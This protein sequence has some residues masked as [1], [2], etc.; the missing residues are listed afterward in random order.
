MPWHHP[1]DMQS[2][3]EIESQIKLSQMPAHTEGQNEWLHLRFSVHSFRSEQMACQS[4][5]SCGCSQ[6]ILK[7]R[8]RWPLPSGTEGDCICSYQVSQDSAEWTRKG[9]QQTWSL[10]TYIPDELL[11]HSRLLHYRQSSFPNTIT[12]PPC[13][14]INGW[15]S[16]QFWLLKSLLI[17]T[18]AVSWSRHRERRSD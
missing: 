1:P 7:Q 6:R 16:G 12:L 2:H 5:S 14:S 11:T 4:F 3:I 17:H 8:H 15:V 10:L 18:T 9:G 13:N